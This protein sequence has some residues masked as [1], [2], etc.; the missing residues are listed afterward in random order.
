MLSRYWETLK[1]T[2]RFFGLGIWGTFFLNVHSAT[3][4]LTENHFQNFV[5]ISFQKSHTSRDFSFVT[6]LI[7]LFW[8]WW[9][10]V[11]RSVDLQCGA[12]DFIVNH[13]FSFVKTRSEQFFGARKSWKSQQNWKDALVSVA[14]LLENQQKFVWMQFSFAKQ[15]FQTTLSANIDR[16]LWRIQFGTYS[17]SFS[18]AFKNK[19]DVWNIFLSINILFERK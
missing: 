15:V 2:L 10:F 11:S 8:V 17:G 13:L 7:H 6:K 16:N 18:S 19:K 5:K 3:R 14:R 12:Y 9:R 4:R 1:I